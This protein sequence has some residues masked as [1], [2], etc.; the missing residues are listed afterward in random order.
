MKHC[1][2]KFVSYYNISF[3]I[4]KGI[5]NYDCFSSNRAYKITLYLIWQTSI[6]NRNTQ[7]RS[8]FN[9]ICCA[10]LGV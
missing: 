7:H 1:M 5:I 10:G 9:R 2:A 8:Y 3:T 4:I 6:Y